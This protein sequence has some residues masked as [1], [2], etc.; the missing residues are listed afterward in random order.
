MYFSNSH[1]S[2][3]LPIPAMP[4]TE[5]SCALLLVR[6]A[7][8]RSLTRRSSRS[9]PTNGASSPATCATPRDAGDHAQ[10]PPERDRLRL[11]LELVLAG[12]LVHDRCLASRAASPRPRTPCPGSAADWTREAVLTRSPAT[13][14]WPSAPIVTAASPVRT[15]AR[16]WSCEPPR[17]R[18]RARRRPGRARPGPR[19][20][21]RPRRATGVPQTAI[22]ASPMNFS[23]VPP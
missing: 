16:A 5:T 14:P 2:R 8:K 15:P 4:V 13:M 20:P 18:A 12:V 17:R 23:T 3:D 10:R 21:R 19:A 11:A 7:W 6:D 1:A 9:R 22:T